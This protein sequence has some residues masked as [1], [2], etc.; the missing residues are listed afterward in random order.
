MFLF[1]QTNT[2]PLSIMR[3]RNGWTISEHSIDSDSGTYKYSSLVTHSGVA[4]R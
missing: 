3:D 1:W 4:D 2:L